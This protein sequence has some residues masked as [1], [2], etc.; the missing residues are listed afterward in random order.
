MSPEKT[1][2]AARIKYEVQ[3]KPINNAETRHLEE[4]R[5][6]EALKPKHSIQILGQSSANGI[7][8]HG[9][10]AAAEK[11]S[12]FIVSI[13]LAAAPLRLGS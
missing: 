4:L 3:C 1:K 12:N 7:I 10:A 2:I 5:A 9:S 13:F 11:F 6:R 8:S